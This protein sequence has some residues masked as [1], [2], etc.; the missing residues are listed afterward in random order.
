MI[1][2][3]GAQLQSEAG[4][5]RIFRPSSSRPEKAIAADKEFG[6][7]GVT[8]P[9]AFARLRSRR[10]RSNAGRPLNHRLAHRAANATDASVP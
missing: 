2:E 9:L 10:V 6:R 8:S 4:S 3:A 7:G 5:W 1:D